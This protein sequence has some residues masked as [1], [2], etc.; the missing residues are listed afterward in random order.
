MQEISLSLRLA[1][2]S[3]ALLSIS[4]HVFTFVGLEAA[5]A[6]LVGMFV[7]DCFSQ[8]APV[9]FRPLAAAFLCGSIQFMS[10][11]AFEILTV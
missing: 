11:G 5:E 1:C 10:H 8:S 6:L 9:I 2:F 3:N 4:F 7:V